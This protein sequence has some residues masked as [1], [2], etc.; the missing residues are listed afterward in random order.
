M[1]G[2]AMFDRRDMKF[3]NSVSVPLFGERLGTPD[4]RP[5]R[6]KRRKAKKAKSDEYTLAPLVAAGF[7]SKKSAEI[8]KRGWDESL[9]PRGWH[10]RFGHGVGG[11]RDRNHK[12]DISP[13]PTAAPRRA[14]GARKTTVSRAPVPR[15]SA[16]AAATT[17]AVPAPKKT[18]VPR[19]AAAPRKTSVSSAP[20]SV[21]ASTGSYDHKSK[22]IT[23]KKLIPKIN[24][25]GTH[26]MYDENKKPIVRAPYDDPG[27]AY[28]A[29]NADPKTKISNDRL[30]EIFED[31]SKMT[32]GEKKMIASAGG[33]KSLDGSDTISVETSRGTRHLE[34]YAVFGQLRSKIAPGSG[35]R[36]A[37]RQGADAREKQAAK[38]RSSGKMSAVGFGKLTDRIKDDWSEDGK[39]VPC[40]FCS[41]KL[42]HEAM[43]VETASPK[44]LGGNYKNRGMTWPAHAEC[45]TKAGKYAQDDPVAYLEEMLKK[46]YKLPLSTR[47]RLPFVYDEYPQ[48]GKYPGTAAERTKYMK[49]GPK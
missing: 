26:I 16:A 32:A 8:L 17:V 28:Y 14:T 35:N 38:R 41:K 9:H 43:S 29:R 20:K 31:P 18:P 15:K 25:G 46:F 12:D 4:I 6:R 19:V 44:A 33:A 45:N 49:E 37:T 34:R 11:P 3:A 42:P 47:K 30:K 22:S 10:G 48:L 27:K 39:T 23:D 40:V 5:N 24:R 2:S 1:K 7:M 13:F 36:S 21:P